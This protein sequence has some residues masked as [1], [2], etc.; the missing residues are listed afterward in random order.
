ML[1]GLSKGKLLIG[2]GAAL[3]LLLL[4]RSARAQPA[5]RTS[6]VGGADAR[7]GGAGSTGGQG[8][9]DEGGDDDDGMLW[10]IGGTATD[11]STGETC[12]L[13]NGRIECGG[14]DTGDYDF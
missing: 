5:S 2:G 14:L 8:G 10:D 13:V 4:W 9:L 7:T 1:F 12:E 6:P 11:N 3:L